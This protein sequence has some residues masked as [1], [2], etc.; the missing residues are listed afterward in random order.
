ME[1]DQERIRQLE[2][3]NASQ[4]VMLDDGE[5]YANIKEWR[6]AIERAECH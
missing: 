1:S 3:Q 6:A 4:K 5:P 2:Q